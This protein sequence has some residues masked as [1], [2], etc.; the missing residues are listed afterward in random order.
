MWIAAAE[1]IAM[2]KKVVRC[3]CGFAAEGDDAELVPVVQTHVR[4]V[5]RM[6][7]TRDQ[8]L[9]VAEPLE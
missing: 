4:D 8:V 1:E 5:H 7:Y 3:Y 2:A 9:A 6:E